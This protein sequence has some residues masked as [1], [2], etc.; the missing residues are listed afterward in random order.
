ME[1]GLG[2]VLQYLRA[3]TF[4]RD[5]NWK[6]TIRLRQLQSEFIRYQFFLNRISLSVCYYFIASD[7][8]LILSTRDQDYLSR[9]RAEP[10]R[11]V[12]CAVAGT[13][14]ILQ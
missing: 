6:I 11:V 10:M 9:G 12:R 3:L 4:V 2:A 8:L 5:R 1:A 14:A 13:E 7:V